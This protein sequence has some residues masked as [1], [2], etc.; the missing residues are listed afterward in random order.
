MRLQGWRAVLAAAPLA[1]LSLALTGCDDANDNG[2]GSSATV[3]AT[4]VSVAPVSGASSTPFVFTGEITASGSG[5][6]TYRWVHDD[7]SQTDTQT[8]NFTGAGT[9]TVTHTWDSISCSTSDRSKWAQLQILTPNAMS[10]A[11]TAITVNAAG[12]CP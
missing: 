8:L 2:T 3:T 9:Q 4:T 1:V 6:V 5:P 10:S 12:N 7:G 11:Q